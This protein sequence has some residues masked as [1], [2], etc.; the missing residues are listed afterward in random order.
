MDLFLYELGNPNTKVDLSNIIMTYGRKLVSPKTVTKG[1]WYFEYTH[2]DGPNYDMI[3][4]TTLGDQWS[5]LFFYKK[6]E[7]IDYTMYSSNCVTWVINYEIIKSINKFEYQTVGLMLDIENK[8]F[9]IRVGNEI[10][11]FPFNCTFYGEKWTAVVRYALVNYTAN[12]SVNLGQ[13]VFYY[14]LPYG[15]TPWTMNGPTGKKIPSF[16]AK[17]CITLFLNIFFK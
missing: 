9:S 10:S 15:Y 4:F 3:G 5:D 6:N 13:N 12:L 7:N 1:K 11:I 16:S 17:A 14:D 2:N 8:V